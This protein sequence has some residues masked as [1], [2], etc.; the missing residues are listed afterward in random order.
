MMWLSF[1]VAAEIVERELGL[2]W[3]AAQKALMD[4][5]RADKLRYQNRPSGGPDVFDVDLHAWL[6][7]E[8]TPPK[9]SARKQALAKEAISAIW[10]EGLPAT[11][12]NGVLEQQVGEW[13]TKHHG[14]HQVPERS[15][16]LRAAGRKALRA[17]P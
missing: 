5:C 8:T 14:K 3:G 15:T 13:I 17:K 12:G 16:I 7:L 11:V 1:V 10:P 4:A 9:R 6:R 2:S